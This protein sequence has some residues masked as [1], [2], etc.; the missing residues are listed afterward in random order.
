VN[1]LTE[2]QLIRGILDKVDS[3]LTSE[4][5]LSFAL[6]GTK[7]TFDLL[8]CSIVLVDT[9]RRYFKV[10]LSKGWSNEFV[11][12]FHASPFKG[13]VA[14]L[15]KMDEPMAVRRGDA[16]HN[17]EGYRFEEEYASLLAVPLAIRGKKIGLLCLSSSRADDFAPERVA[18]C[19]D[20]AN[21]CALILAHGNLEQEVLTLSD[22]DPLTNLYSY[23]YWHEELHREVA[24]SEKMKNTLSIMEVRL[25][26]LR[27]YNSGEGHARGDEALI[28]FSRVI[29]A[30]VDDIDVACRSGSKWYVLLTGKDAKAARKTAE[31]IVAAAKA[32]P[33]RGNPPLALSVGVAVYEKGEGE[34][35]FVNRAREA[36][37]EARRKGG[38]ACHIR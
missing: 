14:D 30:A 2:L 15:A 20:L 3:P 19:R 13:L 26:H 7:D 29:R 21:L 17:A 37:T 4:E 34:D 36:L 22:I 32:L 24:R 31:A 5:I 16:R 11:K 23:K 10:S 38:T 1:P 9:S 33:A 12:S 8:A 18:M 27:E 35:D 25:N 6:Q 28:A